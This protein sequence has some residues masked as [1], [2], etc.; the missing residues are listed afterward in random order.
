[1]FSRLGFSQ[2]LKNKTK[3]SART[4]DIASS[5]KSLVVGAQ[6]AF[7]PAQIVAREA[8]IVARVRIARIDLTGLLQWGFG[9]FVITLGSVRHAK[10]LPAARVGRRDPR[11]LL[12]RRDCLVHSAAPEVF[13][14]P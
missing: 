6:C 3:T 8:E 7:V 1:M 13:R 2:S 5:L 4:P 9:A 10:T 14:A 11:R 12:K